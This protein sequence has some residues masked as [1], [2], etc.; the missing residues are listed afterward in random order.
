MN[1]YEIPFDATVNCTDRHGGTS[2]AVTLHPVS[3]NI[4][5]IVV[6]DNDGQ[7]RLVPLNLIDKTGDDDVWL[8]CTED[9]LKKKTL[10]LTTEYVDR[11]PQKSGDWS[12][13][14]GEWED[15]VD[16]S[17]FERTDDA[18]MPVVVEKVPPGEIALH[19]KTDIEATDGHLGEVERFLIEPDSG[20]ITHLVWEKGHLWGKKH[21]MI[22]LTAV[23]SV[24]YDSVYLN[25]DQAAAENFPEQPE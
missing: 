11:A 25:V 6:E 12:E 2:V 3:R 18:G 19:R 14:E 16:V 1:M 22:P 23:D 7:Q 15:G 4:T 24:D 5:H 20:H 8:N 10:F 13:K 9:Q 17:Q 21:I